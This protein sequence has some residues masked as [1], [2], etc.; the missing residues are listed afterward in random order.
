MIPRLALPPSPAVLALIALAFVLP[1]LLHEPWKSIDVV[2]IALSNEMLRS[3]DWLVPRLAGE[4]WLDDMPLYHWVALGFGAALGSLL[5]FHEAARMASGLFVLLAVWL[6]VQAARSWAAPESRH[7]DGASAALLLV[8]SVGLMVHA[9]EAVPELAAPAA[10]AGAFAALARAEQQSWNQRAALGWGA[11]FGAAL[12]AAFL[13]TGFVIPATTFAAALLA[14]LV[15]DAWRSPRAPLF[16]G[17]AALVAA[18]IAAA[19]LTGLSLRAPAAPAAWWAQATQLHGEFGENLRY[20]LVVLTWFAWPA[21][22]LAL[23]AIWSMRRRWREPQL[24]MPLAATVLG[25]LGISLIGPTQTVNALALL[26]PLALLAVRGVAVLRRGAAA[27]L[28]WFGV[29]TFGVFVAL[30]WL[31]YVAMMTGVPPRIANNFLKISPGFIAHFDARA[32]LAA[33]VLSLAWLYLMF[34]TRPS[35]TRSLV[36]WAAGVILLWGT[37]ATLWLPWAEYQKSYRS[38]AL[39]LRSKIPAGDACI[40]GKN[41]GAPQRAALDYHAGIRAGEFD[42][43]LPSTCPLLLV[44]GHPSHESDRPGAGWAKLADVGRPGD[45][46]ERFRL[47]GIK[48]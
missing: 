19:W 18:A 7:V 40:A 42:F 9:H 36:R 48:Q 10:L 32:L 47:Y 41:L 46:S 13:S 2:T 30:V 1:G 43:R 38:V 20:F 16:L 44:Q 4:P 6:L 14:H 45:K 26:V 24:F 28:D 34:F 33:L 15:C 25:L 5:Q 3:G 37:F 35:A 29:M 23:W 21:W 11:V 31:G 22:P 12:G 8:G 39:Q 27:A 17:A